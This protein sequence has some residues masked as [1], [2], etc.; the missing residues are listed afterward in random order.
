MAIKLTRYMTLILLAMIF[1]AP[2]LSAYFFYTH[3]QWLNAS[4]VNKG[5]LLTP[6]I[7]LKAL[8]ESSKWRL[9]LW[10]P[11]G[12]K[13]ACIKQLDKLA[14]VRLALGRKLY[15]VE[16]WLLTGDEADEINQSAHVLIKQADFQVGVLKLEP[17]TGNDLLS[18]KAKL[19]IVNPDRYAIL[20]YLSE[21]DPD[22]IYKDLKLL[23]SSTE[24]KSG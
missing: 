24:Q 17:E 21:T 15:Q 2:G 6:P 19:L 3:P 5:T 8:N 11:K 12:C 7:P 10:S 18:N 9:V 13:E 4:R 23:L 14:R 16:L 1:V 20:S 22:D